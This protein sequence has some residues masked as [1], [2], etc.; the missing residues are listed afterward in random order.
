MQR[1]EL[2]ERMC[3]PGLLPV[4]RTH[5]LEHLMAASRAYCEAGISCIEY[6]LTMPDALTLVH[7]AV[8]ELPAGCAVGAGTVMDPGTVELAVQ[9]GATF[10]AG[11]GFCPEVVAACRRLGVVSVVGAITP[12]EIML[13][14]RA[15]ADVIKVFPASAVG[16][17]FFAEVLGPFPG[18]RLMA[19]GGINLGNVS[20]YVRA[21]ASVVTVLANGLAAPAYEEGRMAD[22]RAA[23]QQLL[24]TIAAARRPA[25]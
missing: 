20:D 19:A 5:Q 6:T 22:L 21:G 15:G 11:P 17:S 25:A 4:F 16:P 10:I 12:T 2:I 7:R 1:D 24:T 3:G 8:A 18:V 14:L 9:A 23:A 13:A